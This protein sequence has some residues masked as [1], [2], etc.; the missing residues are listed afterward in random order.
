MSVVRLGEGTRAGYIRIGAREIQ[1][2]P[3]SASVDGVAALDYLLRRSVLFA[4]VGSNEAQF[5]HRLFLEYFAASELV[6]RGGRDEL[7]E[8]FD[9]P[10]WFSLAAHYCALAPLHEAITLV[11][12]L[13]AKAE[14]SSSKQMGRRLVYCIVECLGAIGS[15]QPK[16]IEA[17]RKLLSQSLPPAS[18]EET[19]LLASI[20]DSALDM[21][22]I[23]ET[24][25]EAY[26]YALTCTKVLGSKAVDLLEQYSQGHFSAS[27]KSL[28]VDS[29]PSFEAR[30]YARRVLANYTFHEE[31]VR[32]SSGQCATAHRI[33]AG[34]NE[35][36]YGDLPW[37]A[38][39]SAFDFRVTPGIGFV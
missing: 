33:S 24:E 29:W 39:S 38:R 28:L 26:A 35:C 21:F 25:D 36:F 16:L 13:I 4:R 12:V 15:Y 34:R 20:G 22:P 27:L 3:A 5:A 17:V 23:P 31:S 7:L 32:V 18:N 10:G 8:H 14:P 30:D 37:V 6:D 9:K 2:Q 1:L 11:Q 19:A